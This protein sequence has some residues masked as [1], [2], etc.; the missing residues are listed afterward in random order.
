MKYK[1]KSM[2]IIYI[3]K[4]DNRDQNELSKEIYYK[5]I[6]KIKNIINK[7][8]KISLNVLKIC[9]KLH[10]NKAQDIKIS[11]FLRNFLKNID[12]FSVLSYNI[13]TRREMIC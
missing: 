6:E 5:I 3:R 12:I 2:I 10:T 1:T 13:L 7:S 11:T 9:N 8:E 4:F